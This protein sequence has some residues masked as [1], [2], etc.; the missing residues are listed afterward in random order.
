[1]ELIN[2]VDFEYAKAESQLFSKKKDKWALS[3]FQMV[4][5]QPPCSGSPHGH[6]CTKSTAAIR[7]L[8]TDRK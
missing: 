7:W 8:G 6:K 3:T 1:M 4:E 2:D 5:V